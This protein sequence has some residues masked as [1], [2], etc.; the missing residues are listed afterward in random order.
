ME[1]PSPPAVTHRCVRLS[2]VSEMI[3]AP[4]AVGWEP[5]GLSPLAIATGCCPG[6]ELAGEQ[7]QRG[8]ARRPLA[9]C[10]RTCCMHKGYEE[11]L[12]CYSSSRSLG[13]LLL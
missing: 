1:G 10:R 5:H 13:W 3:G 7:D 11:H 6:L 2:L 4:V 8:W 12:L 9:Q